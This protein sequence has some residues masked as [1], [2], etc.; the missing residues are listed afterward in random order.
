MVMGT[1]IPSMA[2]PDAPSNILDP[3]AYGLIRD[4]QQQ[5]NIHARLHG[6]HAA[7]EMESLPAEAARNNR[8]ELPRHPLSEPSGPT[9]RK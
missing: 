5:D 8:G 1:G 4:Q 3:G 2:T 7:S 6:L 9:E